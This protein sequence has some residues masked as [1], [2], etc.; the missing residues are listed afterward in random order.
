MNVL[1]REEQ[2]H[3]VATD[4]TDGGAVKKTPLFHRPAVV[5][6]AVLLLLVGIVYGAT[7]GLHSFTHESTDD[8]FIDAHIVAIAPKGAGR[9]AD[10]PVNDNKDVKAGAPLVDIDPAD[11]EA[12][13][14]QRRA[15]V[16]AAQ[17]KVRNAEASAQQAD[18]HLNT[19]RAGFEAAGAT[20]SGAA[21]DVNKQVSDLERNR[22]LAATGAISQQEF[23]HSTADTKVSQANL[24]SKKKQIDA[25]AAFLQESEK[26]AEAAH[27]QV[28]AATAAVTEA[29]AAMRESELTLS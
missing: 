14:A 24:E 16:D 27:V 15:A 23:E 6:A 1:E 10:A 5:V 26:S 9:V 19:V 22:Q 8:A 29:E 18:A 20:A 12:V 17:A 3:V 11:E 7:A 4:T 21:A 13:L 25:A 28:E 2:P